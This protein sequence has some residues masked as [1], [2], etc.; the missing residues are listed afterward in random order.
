MMHTVYLS[1]GSNLGNRESNLRKAGNLV[2]ER[3]GELVAASSL[4]LSEPW[5]FYH[6][7]SFYNQVLKIS[8]SLNSGELLEIMQDI[9]KE[10]GRVRQVSRR[11]TAR[12]I[13]I[14]LLFYDSLI[15]QTDKLTLPHPL[16]Q[17]RLFVLMPLA[18]I[19]P[20]LQHPVLQMTVIS[21]MQQCKDNLKVTRL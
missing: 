10:L 9:E 14:D 12:K 1:L 18:E 3:A 4:Y 2:K 20:D 19:A 8:T 6:P 21:L 17:Y 7:R 16:I 5:G 13:D 11:Y 15:L